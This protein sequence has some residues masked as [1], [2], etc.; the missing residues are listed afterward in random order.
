MLTHSRLTEILSYDPA[1]GCFT[2]KVDVARNVKAGTVA[3]NTNC[4]GYMRIRIDKKAYF[5]HRLAWFYVTGEWPKATIDHINRKKTDNRF[6]N[7]RDISLLANQHNR[8]SAKP[9]LSK[10]GRWLISIKAEGKL[11][12][13]GSHPTYAA[14]Q[15]AYN[16]AKNKL[17]LIPG[18]T[19]R[20]QPCAP[21]Q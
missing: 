4:Y 19:E 9:R 21:Q 6:A 7:L 18:T 15:A 17:H 11:H 20:N 10:S 5:A 14:A 3:G 1:T 16:A 12:S 2:W 13:L 8:P